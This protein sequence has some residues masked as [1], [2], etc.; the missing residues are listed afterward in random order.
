MFRYGYGK[1]LLVRLHRRAFRAAYAAPTALLAT[2]L[3]GALIPPA[4]LALVPF[5]LYSLLAAAGAIRGRRYLGLRLLL[6]LLM[7]VGFG[8]GFAC[9]LV[10]P[11]AMAH[12]GTGRSRAGAGEPTQERSSP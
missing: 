2:A 12:A 9:G 1:A 4:R 6:S 10:G 11:R 5:G 8:A 3:A 7:V